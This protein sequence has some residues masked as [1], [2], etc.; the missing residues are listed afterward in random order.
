MPL[1]PT[2]IS[3]SIAFFVVENLDE[4]GYYEGNSEEFCHKHGIPLDEFEKVR[5]RFAHVE[6]VGIAAKD[7]AESF[8]FQ[9]DSSDISDEAYLLC[10]RVIKDINAIHDYSDEYNFSEVMRVLSTFKNPPSIEY[11]EESRQI[12]PDLMI[13]FNAILNLSTL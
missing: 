12:V 2:P 6:P 10:V 4:N 9:L 1:F 11:Q 7:L 13:F 3:Q 5:L 8:I